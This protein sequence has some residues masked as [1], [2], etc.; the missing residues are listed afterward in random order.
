MLRGAYLP[1]PIGTGAA[2]VRATADGLDYLYRKERWS[3]SDLSPD[4]AARSIARSQHQIGR[5]DRRIDHF[6]PLHLGSEGEQ[7]YTIRR[8]SGALHGVHISSQ[9]WNVRCS[10]ASSTPPH[11]RRLMVAR[12]GANTAPAP[13]P[14]RCSRHPRGVSTKGDGSTAKPKRHSCARGFARPLLAVG[15]RCSVHA[16]TSV[17]AILSLAF[18]R[19][20]GHGRS[21]GSPSQEQY[22]K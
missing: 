2:A 14:R 9:G 18:R 12:R 1:V 5:I 11:R 4:R 15:D 8:W 16:R 10:V 19:A 7:A 3:Q 6:W 21:I 22:S 17:R 20:Q 13:S